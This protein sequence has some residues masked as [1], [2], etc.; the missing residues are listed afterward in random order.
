MMFSERGEYM[1]DA[2]TTANVLYFLVFHQSSALNI[3]SILP[4][5]HTTEEGDTHHMAHFNRVNCAL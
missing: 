2:E 3:Q 5:Q 1:R 4:D